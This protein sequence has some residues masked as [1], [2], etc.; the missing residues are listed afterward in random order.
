MFPTLPFYGPSDF[1]LGKDREEVEPSGIHEFLSLDNRDLEERKSNFYEL[2][3]FLKSI[4]NLR[5][6]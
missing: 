6:G 3:R 5:V 1:V 4:G 2:R